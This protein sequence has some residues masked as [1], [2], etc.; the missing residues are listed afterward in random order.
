MLWSF[1]PR[2]PGA[3]LKA[4]PLQHAVIQLTQH[5][6]V[7]GAQHCAW[8]LYC[9]NNLFHSEQLWQL[10]VLLC[11]QG[12]ALCLKKLADQVPQQHWHILML[13]MHAAQQSMCITVGEQLTA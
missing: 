13:L 10:E 11:R 4:Q 1:T 5:T 3:Q 8:Q 7:Q 2:L 6:F 12:G 9:D